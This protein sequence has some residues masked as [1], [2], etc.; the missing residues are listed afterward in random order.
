MTLTNALNSSIS[1]LKAT[2]A[3]ID[4]VS[5]NIAN[6]STPGYSRKSVT[7]S[8][9]LANGKSI[10]VA[11]SAAQR[12]IDIFQQQQLRV[13][14]AD[15][16]ASQTISN[17]LDRIDSALGA[18]ESGLSLAGR[19]AD[20]TTALQ[21]LATT[22][23]NASIR[24][25][26]LA[27]ADDFADALNG[28]SELVQ[29]LRLEAE[30]GLANAVR[31]A[32]EQLQRVASLNNQ[33]VLGRATSGESADLEDQRDLAI[34]RLSQLMDINV[35]ARDDGAVSLFTGGGFALLD[36][37]SADISFDERTSIGTNSLYNTDPSLRTVGTITLTSGSTQI[38]LIASGAFRSGEIAALI[39]L[40]DNVL[41]EAQAQLDE[42]ASEL[43]L[44]LSAETT[45]GTAA[46]AGAATGFEVDTASLLSGNTINLTYTIG[47]TST[48]VTIVK[49]EDPS[50]LPLANSATNNPNDTVIGIDWTQPIG[51]IV[52]DLNAALP[53]EVVVSNP[54]GTLLRFVDDGVAATSDIDALSTTVTPTA[55]ID[56]GTGIALF[57]DGNSQTIYSNSL[58]GGGQKQGLA[59]RIRINQSL[60]ADNSL[61]VVYGTS[62]ATDI[63]DPTRP[64]DLI[65]R[66]TGNSRTYASDSGIGS[67]TSPFSGT[68]DSFTRRIVDFQS[69]QAANAKN[70]VESN[71]IIS[72]TLQARFSETVG[73]DIDTELSDLLIL[74]TAYAA[75]ARILSTIKDLMDIMLT[76]GR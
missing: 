12:D 60:V 75:N 66:L 22:P 50:I 69:T 7:T 16:I 25:N 41:P 27:E 55:L 56:A 46:T 20:F 52:N 73:V 4:I 65:A 19:L 10:G 30:H 45:A 18:P 15:T 70:A 14:R 28:S 24:A 9:V 63:G 3:G 54:S 44:S 57:V 67:S 8:S 42:L 2:Q 29:Q 40:R 32:N 13:S 35:V 59:H 39:D 71:K 36:S 31:E 68:I 23:E 61:L 72:D 38:D 26:V 58:D 64:L 6:A 49:V 74:E 11:F 47:G 53:A 33:I 76:I 5:R 43:I 34:D 48:T 1:G 37:T 21:S 62:P 51:D 17:Y